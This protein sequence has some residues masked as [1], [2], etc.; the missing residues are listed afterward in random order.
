MNFL[1]APVLVILLRAVALGRR[2]VVVRVMMV[3]VTVLMRMT[4]PLRDRWAG[5]SRALGQ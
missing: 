4:A 3:V 5:A 2:M 1:Q